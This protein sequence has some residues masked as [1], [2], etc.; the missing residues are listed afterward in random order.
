MCPREFISLYS[1]ISGVSCDRFRDTMGE[2]ED[3][4]LNRF[5]YLQANDRLMGSSTLRVTP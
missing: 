4:L 3:T 1:T 5:R 2:I